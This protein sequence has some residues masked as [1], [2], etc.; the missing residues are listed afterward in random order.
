MILSV[1]APLREYGASATGIDRILAH[2]GA[3]R[4]SVYHH[5]PGGR[6][7]LIDD[8]VAPAGDFIAG[9]I[10][11]AVQADDPVEAVDA[12]FALWRDR[13]VESD[14]R[15]G[16]PIVAVAVE[17]NDNAPRLAR[18]TA[19]VFARWQEALAALLIRH[20]PAEERSRRLGAFIIT[21]AEGVVIMCRAERSTA[22]IGAAAVE[23]HDL[24]VYAP[25]DRP[26]S[27]SGPRHKA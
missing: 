7:Q 18:S 27:E 25:H 23:I 11:A 1:A 4:G 6:A 8:A 3:T 10:D 2:S 26:G 14:F 22:P 20:R 21:A 5:F 24:L 16:C 12:F 9:L 17:T 13:L 15:A 19:A